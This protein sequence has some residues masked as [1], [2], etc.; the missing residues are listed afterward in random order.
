MTEARLSFEPNFNEL[1]TTT[2]QIKVT[3]PTLELEVPTNQCRELH[4]TNS[5]RT[6]VVLLQPLF[7]SI[8]QNISDSTTS[9]KVDGSRFNVWSH[10]QMAFPFSGS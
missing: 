5:E 7:A 2:Q 8:S 1:C 6:T 10:L 3:A 4:W 9:S